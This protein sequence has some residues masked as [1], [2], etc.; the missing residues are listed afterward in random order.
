MTKVNDIAVDAFQ[1]VDK[2]IY[3]RGIYLRARPGA[4]REAVKDDAF[5]RGW[6]EP[7]QVDLLTEELRP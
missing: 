5:R 7:H 1:A 6:L 3:V 2:V 4:E